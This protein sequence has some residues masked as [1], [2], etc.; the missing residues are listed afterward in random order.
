MTHQHTLDLAASQHGLPTTR[1]FLTL[2]CT[3]RLVRASKV[4][5]GL[6]ASSIERLS[7]LWPLSFPTSST[8]NALSGQTCIRGCGTHHS[9][10]PSASVHANVCKDGSHCKHTVLVHAP[11]TLHG[12]WA[13]NAWGSVA[14]RVNRPRH[15]QDQHMIFQNDCPQGPNN[16]DECIF[17]HKDGA[18]CEQGCLIVD[19]G[20]DES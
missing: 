11:R 3:Y 18:G 9:T 17:A 19:Q 1:R 10:S 20:S 7:R 15:R 13:A 5:A 12:L 14:S 4:A 8:T 2:F 6:Q 16:D